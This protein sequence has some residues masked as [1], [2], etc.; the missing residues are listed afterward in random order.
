MAEAVHRAIIKRGL[1]ST[2]VSP[3]VDSLKSVTS[4]GSFFDFVSAIAKTTYFTSKEPGILERR[5]RIEGSLD[6]TLI[7]KAVQNQDFGKT[8]P[9]SPDYDNL[10]AATS[11]EKQIERE[12]IRNVV[13]RE[14]NLGLSEAERIVL[15]GHCDLGDQFDEMYRKWRKEVVGNQLLTELKNN[16]RAKGQILARC[17]LKGMP[18]GY[19]YSILKGSIDDVVLTPYAEAFPEEMSA[20]VVTVTQMS[21]ELRKIDDAE[22][23]NLA[24]YYEAFGTAITSQNPKDHD[25]LWKLVDKKWMKVSGR[26]QPIHP[27][28]SY[29]DPNGLLVEP[30]LAL[31]FRDDRAE[32][33]ATNDLTEVTKRNMIGHLS[34]KY[35]DKTSLKTSI[36]P[37]TSSIAGVFSSQGAGR[38]LDF[39]PAGQNIPNRTAIRIHDGVKIFLDMETMHQRWKIQRNLLVGIF[40]EEFVKNQFDNE[41]NLIPF[42]TGIHVAGHEVAHNAFV[43]EGTR[44]LIGADNYAQIEEQKSDMTILTAAP[45]WLN[46]DEQKTFLKAIFAGEVRSLALKNDESRRPYYNSA[47]FI[48][49]QMLETGIVFHDDAGWHYDDSESKLEV[50][51]NKARTIMSN[52]FVPVYEERSPKKA[53][54]YIKKNYEPSDALVQFEQSL[55]K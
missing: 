42:A 47:V 12:V 29:V 49:N 55:I 25:R 33:A 10:L 45:S 53:A 38:R 26:M 16:P 7:E 54:T 4:I 15:L 27:M 39:R 9:A 43:Q 46:P 13:Q 37:M 6:P 44:D 14:N 35:G 18:D 3:R 22:S 31:T 41:P 34:D 17:N 11:F 40:G 51:F 8:D 50:F 19:L 21:Q 2:E 5:R 36:G 32:A 24:D 1:Q 28:E 20:I 48:I 23:S 30:D 52:E